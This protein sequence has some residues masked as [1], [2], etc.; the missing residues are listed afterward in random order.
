ME[1]PLDLS[2]RTALSFY[3]CTMWPEQSVIVNVIWGNYVCCV[4]IGSER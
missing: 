3:L 4:P 1:R 2:G